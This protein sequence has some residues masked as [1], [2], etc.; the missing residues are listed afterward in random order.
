MARKEAKFTVT[1]D[2][3]QAE[4]QLKG[5][6]KQGEAVAGR[7][8]DGLNRGGGMGIGKGF[9]VGAALGAGVRVA[10]G[11]SAGPIGDV[12]GEAVAGAAGFVDRFLEAPDARARRMTREQSSDMFAIQAGQTNDTSQ[13]QAFYK[14]KLPFVQAKEQGRAAIKRDILAGEGGAT[15]SAE[16]AQMDKLGDKIVHALFGGV[17]IILEAIKSIGR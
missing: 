14:Q 4:R 12:F 17:E 11:I 13:A 6:A 7:V 9:G 2:T 1:L 15:Q 3:R 5:V 16:E 8:N 10:R